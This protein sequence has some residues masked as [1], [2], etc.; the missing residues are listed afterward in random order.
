MFWCRKASRWGQGM[1]TS[2]FGNCV[3]ETSGQLEDDFFWNTN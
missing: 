2:N 3:R 1:K